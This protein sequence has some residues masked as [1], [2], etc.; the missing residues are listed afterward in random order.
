MPETVN[1]TIGKHSPIDYGA[2]F[3]YHRPISLSPFPL[4]AANINLAFNAQARM[5]RRE[6]DKESEG[7]RAPVDMCLETLSI[8][9]VKSTAVGNSVVDPCY[10]SYGQAV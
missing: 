6:E 7:W 1:A 2:S 3:Q 4:V 5:G 10:L 8:G 9:V